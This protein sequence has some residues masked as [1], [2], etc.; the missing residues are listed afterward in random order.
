MIQLKCDYDGCYKGS[1]TQ[2][3]L[4]GGFKDWFEIS[5]DEVNRDKLTNFAH[6]EIRRISGEPR[7]PHFHHA[8]CYDHA[9]R[10]MEA[11]LDKLEWV[12]KKKEVQPPVPVRPELEPF[13][14]EDPL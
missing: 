8:C 9:K 5:V 11:L 3:F 4:Q 13:T 7:P 2:P 1:T 12:E 14:T 6:A 10:V